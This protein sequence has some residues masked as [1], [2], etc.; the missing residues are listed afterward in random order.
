MDLSLIGT[1]KCMPTRNE[2]ERAQVVQAI[3]HWA[4][5]RKMTTS[6]KNHFASEVAARFQIDYDELVRSRILQIMSPQE[7]AAAAKG[8]AQVELHT[9]RHR[10]PRDRDLFQ[11]EIRENRAH[12]LECTGR[13]PVH[14]CYPSGDYALAFLPWLR[15]LNVKSA[16]T[17]ELGLAKQGSDPLLLPR[18]LDAMNIDDADFEA[19]LL[20]V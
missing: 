8:G 10:T 9:H 4:D 2:G 1:G 14:F 15:E 3:V 16:T 5:S 11:R 18:V 13:D 12:I 6:D 17:C 19:W 20:G 7:I